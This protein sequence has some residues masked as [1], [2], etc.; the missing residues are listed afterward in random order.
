MI[1]TAALLA[2]IFVCCACRCLRR[3]DKPP[4]VAAVVEAATPTK[5]AVASEG[6]RIKTIRGKK[7]VGKKD[8]A[9]K[10]ARLGAG[11]DDEEEE[12][13]ITPHVGGRTAPSD[14]SMGEVI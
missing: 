10:F 8:R 5:A 4:P 13:G 1:G 9:G 6:K 14:L 3:R 11:D 2:L 12:G 7:A